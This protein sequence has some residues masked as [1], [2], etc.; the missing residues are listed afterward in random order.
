MAF[1]PVTGPFHLYASEMPK[2]PIHALF[3]L[4]VCHLVTQE[5]SGTFFAFL[6]INKKV[7]GGFS[8]LKFG[9]QVGWHSKNALVFLIIIAVLLV[10]PEGLLGEEFAEKFYS[11][12]YR[13]NRLYEIRRERRCWPSSVD[14]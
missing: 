1:L 10:E 4:L 9:H 3:N 2:D 7:A 12:T 6:I 13:P 14:Y 11:I 5:G 8:P